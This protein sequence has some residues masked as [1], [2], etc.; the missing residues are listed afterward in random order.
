L[1]DDAVEPYYSS[2]SDDEVAAQAEWG[3]FAL[4]QFHLSCKSH[5]RTKSPRESASIAC[6]DRL[7]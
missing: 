6:S 7:D 2:L 5:F 1:I 3:D 4:R